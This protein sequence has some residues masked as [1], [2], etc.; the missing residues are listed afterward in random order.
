M[1]AEPAVSD[2]GTILRIAQEIRPHLDGSPVIGL[3]WV[4][5]WTGARCGNDYTTRAPFP[6]IRRTERCQV[7]CLPE[8]P[9]AERV[10]AIRVLKQLEAEAL[11][12][13]GPACALRSRFPEGSLA[14]IADHLNMTGQNPL[15]GSNDSRIGP[16]Y[17]DMTRPYHSGWQDR[18]EQTAIALGEPIQRCVYA[19]VSGPPTPAECRLLVLAGADV[20]GE[21]IVADAIAGVHCGIPVA[22]IAGIVEVRAPEDAPAGGLF[23]DETNEV[24]R[25]LSQVIARLIAS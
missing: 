5:P 12:L 18:I 25:R 9:G 21:G 8:A 20:Y 6:A 16:R 10:L 24:E 23:E 1:S 14:I 22:A 19:G 4:G 17:P 15:T 3:S 13:A 7:F 2:Y 11:I